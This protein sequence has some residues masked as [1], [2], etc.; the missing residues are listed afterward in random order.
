MQQGALFL[1]CIFRLGRYKTR[2]LK[3]WVIGSVLGFS[4]TAQ[5][6]QFATHTIREEHDDGIHLKF[7]VEDL[8]LRDDQTAISQWKVGEQF[9]SIQ[10]ATKTDEIAQAWW[11]LHPSAVTGVRLRN[12]VL[13][14]RLPMPPTPTPKPL[15]VPAKEEWSAEDEAD[16]SE[17]IQKNT[18]ESFSQGSGLLSDCADMGLLFRWVYAREKKLPI[19]NTMGGSGKLFGHFS[20]SSKWDKLKTD[21]DWKKDERFK[22]AMRYLYDHAYT[23]SI[24][25]DLYPILVTPTYLNPGTV[26]MIIRPSS[27]HTQTV[28]QVDDQGIITEWGNEPSAET[29]YVTRIIIEYENTRGF[30]RWRNPRKINDAGTTRWVL[31][32][33]R[34]MP[35]YSREQFEQK[36]E[37]GY[38]YRDWIYMKLGLAIGFRAELQNLV[39]SFQTHLQLRMKLTLDSITTCF[40][41]PCDP[42]SADYEN[43]STPGRD[44]SLREVQSDFLKIIKNPK[45]TQGDIDQAMADLDREGELLFGT[46]LT[47]RSLLTDPERMKRFNSDPRVSFSERWGFA[48]GSIDASAEYIVWANALYSTLVDRAQ[49]VEYGYSYCGQG[50]KCTA[51]QLSEYSSKSYD[52]RLRAIYSWMNRSVRFDQISIEAQHALRKKFA[53]TGLYYTQKMGSRCGEPGLEVCTLNRLIWDAGGSDRIQAFSSDPADSIEKRWGY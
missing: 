43:G 47:Y 4:M 2:M 22:A 34:S 15:W 36:F 39:Q 17:W 14:G 7:I 42:S 50:Q 28:Y 5:A 29:V 37:S 11:N 26:Y 48:P 27:G 30:M 35:G 20:A 13:P 52:D 40:L 6:A 51:Q 3:R 32:S 10:D 44:R 46:G 9:V 41:K 53:E 31:I 38:A 23:G 18:G 25:D 45:L 19:A 24:I 12:K 21:P 8:D 49:I 1:L 16:Y 33:A